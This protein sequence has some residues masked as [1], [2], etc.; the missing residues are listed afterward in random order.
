MKIKGAQFNR[1]ELIWFQTLI[2]NYKVKSGG[3]TEEL[4]MLYEKVKL[5]VENYVKQ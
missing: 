5:L 4:E 3:L 1:R 2:E